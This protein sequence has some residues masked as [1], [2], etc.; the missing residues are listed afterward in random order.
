MTTRKNTRFS[1]KINIGISSCLLGQ[2]IRFDGGHKYD[3][4]IVES[5]GQY[6]NWIPVCPEFELGLGVP[7][8][9]VHLKREKGEIHL[10]SIKANVDLTRSMKDYSDEKLK[11]L[12]GQELRGYIFKKNSPS[13]GLERVKVFGKGTPVRDGQG[14]FAKAVTEKFPNLPVEEEGRLRNPSLRE[15]WVERI[16]AYHALRRLFGGSWKL[17]ELVDFHSRYKLVLMAHSN[18]HYLEL[19]RMVARAKGKDKKEFAEQYEKNFMEAL[20]KLATRAK[21]TNVLQHVI[22][23]FKK[24]ISPSE[25]LELLEVI[26]DYR[27]GL[28]P[29]SVP[30][31]LVLHYVKKFDL[32]YLLA[33]SY[34]DPHPKELALRN[35]C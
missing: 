25:K 8:E 16:F 15:N 1:E 29:L 31:V 35:F 27:A 28:Y 14:L 26:E 9:P 34:F 17:G 33:Q 12:S 3:E 7:R 22:G 21:H 20:A 11:L 30:L 19:G 6:L 32:K 5:L 23:Y 2:K 24:Q 13:C 18:V 4:L 10:V